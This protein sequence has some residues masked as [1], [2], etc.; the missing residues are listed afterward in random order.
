M[1]ATDP[2]VDT[3]PVATARARL[4]EL[5]YPEAA[6]RVA[7]NRGGWPTMPL[8]VRLLAGVP[9]AAIAD[10]FLAGHQVEHPA[11]HQRGRGICCPTCHPE[12]HAG[13]CT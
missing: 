6:E 4:V 5:G 13:W 7:T 2:A 10:A 8:E 9:E 11:A 12:L 3:A 1:T